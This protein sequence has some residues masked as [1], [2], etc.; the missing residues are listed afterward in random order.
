MHELSIASSLRDQVL[1]HLPVGLQLHKVTIEVGSL[2]H[3][4]DA[5]MQLAWEVLC[6]EP[7]LEG[8]ALTI[9][10]VPVLVRC[11]AC[12]HEHAPEHQAPLHCPLCG[13]ARPEV[14]EGWGIVLKS[15]ETDPSYTNGRANHETALSP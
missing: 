6:A 8:S 15:L 9:L 1:E 5:V 4:D 13:K 10:H 3:L 12:D 2:E 7:P 11:R 14:L